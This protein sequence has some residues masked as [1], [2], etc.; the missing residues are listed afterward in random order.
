MKL[1]IV[2]IVNP[3]SGTRQRLKKQLPKAIARYLN[4][5]LFDYTIRFTEYPGHAHD[6]AQEI[7]REQ[8]ADVIA[9]AGGDGSVNEVVGVIL[10][11]AIKLGILPFGS[12]NGLAR[13]LGF[14]MQTRKMIAILNRMVVRNMDVVRIGDE[15]AVS[16]VGV[17]F[18]GFVAKLFE[19]L[20]TRG[21][22]GYAL[23]VLRG[24]FNFPGFEYQLAYN[25]HQLQGKAFMITACNSNQH[26]YNM[27]L[28]PRASLNDG[29]LDV[30]VVNDFPRWKLPWIVGLVLLNQHHRS[31][32]FTYVKAR[33]IRLTTTQRVHLHIDGEPASTVHQLEM[34]VL[35]KAI[36]VIAA[37]GKI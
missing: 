36:K 17:G 11:S 34:E 4:H 33:E 8:S 13:H 27:K 12:G 26:G 21:F 1:K 9:V 14:P 32:Y 10:H 6:I 35:Y 3:I 19:R 29:K 18:D 22:W 30:Y 31:K 23:G 20:D 24:A 5:Q 28:A 2:F 15:V 25:G 7:V 37:H 16:N